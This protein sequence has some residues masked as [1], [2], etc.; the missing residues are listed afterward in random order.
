MINKLSDLRLEHDSYISLHIQLHN[1]LRQLIVSQRWNYGERIPTEAQLATHLEISR[2]TVRIALQLAEVEGLIKRNAGRGTFVSYDAQTQTQQKLIAYVTHSFDNEIHR[3]LLSSAETELRSSGYKVIFSKA[4]SGADEVRVLQQL[5]DDGVDGLLLYPN[6]EEMPQQQHILRQYQ[7]QNIPVVFIDRP[8]KGIDA[9]C[10]TSDNF[11][12]SFNIVTYLIELGHRHIVYLKPD[13]DNLFTINERYR[14][15]AGAMQKHG[16]CASDAWQVYVSN[17]HE[18][19]ETDIFQVYS[20]DN[21]AVQS[22]IVK[23]LQTAQPRPTA[24]F[25]AN[26][27]LAIIAAR[28]LSEAGYVIPD[29]ISI[30]GYDDIQLASY[31]TVPLTTVAQDAQKIGELAAQLLL[32]RLDGSMDPPGHHYVDVRL[33]RRASTCT[34]I[35]KSN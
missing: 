33:K 7:M 30:A 31:I 32:D 18:V 24:I 22:D 28:C 1:Q 19:Y 6:A 3:V 27:A 5:L 35:V 26:D 16:L 11:T 2:T 14:G 25:C 13:L 15:Y 23:Q 20:E 12:G 9:D 34:Q 4:A 29:D 17:R 8:V 10:V 21:S